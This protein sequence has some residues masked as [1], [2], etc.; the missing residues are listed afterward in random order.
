MEFEESSSR[1]GNRKESMNRKLI[2]SFGFFRFS[3]TLGMVVVFF[4]KDM[5]RSLISGIT[6]TE[7][8]ET[9]DVTSSLMKT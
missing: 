5:Q 9:L 8:R 1:D 3:D 2:A 7:P 6:D 4:V